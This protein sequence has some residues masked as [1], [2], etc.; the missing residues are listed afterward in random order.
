MWEQLLFLAGNGILC[1]D[2]IYAKSDASGHL[3][4][5]LTCFCCQTTHALTE[6][7]N[8]TTVGLKPSA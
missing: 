7:L 5:I 4:G 1:D 2:K 6:A 3:H 8:G